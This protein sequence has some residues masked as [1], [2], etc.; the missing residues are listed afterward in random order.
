MIHSP[1]RRWPTATHFGRTGTAAHAAS[2]IL[3]KCFKVQTPG[4]RN[5]STQARRR[6]GNCTFRPLPECSRGREGSAEHVRPPGRRPPSSPRPRWRAGSTRR[7]RG[8]RTGGSPPARPPA[9]P[10]H[11]RKADAPSP[12]RRPLAPF[13]SVTS[14]IITRANQNGSDARCRGPAPGCHWMLAP[15]APGPRTRRQS[16]RLRGKGQSAASARPSSEKA[17]PLPVPV[18]KPRAS[19]TASASSNT[20]HGLP[21]AG[22]PAAGAAG[23]RPGL[24]GAPP[25]RRKFLRALPS[26]ALRPAPPR[27]QPLSARRPPRRAARRPAPMAGWATYDPRAPGGPL[28]PVPAPSRSGASP[29]PGGIQRRQKLPRAAPGGGAARVPAHRPYLALGRPRAGRAARGA[30]CASARAWGGR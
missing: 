9:P 30:W 1:P 28:P 21:P 11:S 27:L 22:E 2:L 13:L 19:Q 5:V 29:Q 18:R 6:E 3:N 14:Y 4:A 24:A 16:A 12:T 23:P 15:R 7:G 8:G 26:P 10:R 17:L 25:G 20:F